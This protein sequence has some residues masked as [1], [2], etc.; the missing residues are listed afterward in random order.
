M[1]REELQDEVVRTKF[2]VGD[3]VRF[4]R[5]DPGRG[6]RRLEGTVVEVDPEKTDPLGTYV[7]PQYKIELPAGWAW[8]SERKMEAI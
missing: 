6:T 2:N 5:W 1:T 3:R 7:F 8:V 4:E